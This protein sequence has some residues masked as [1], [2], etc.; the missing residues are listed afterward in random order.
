MIL[1]YAEALDKYGSRHFVRKAL[2]EKQLVRFGQNQYSTDKVYDSMDA[3]IKQYPSAIVTGIT[4]YYIHG[5]TDTVPDTVDLATKRGG[6]K[7]VL[8]YVTQ[9]FIPKEWLDTGSITLFYDGSFIPI[10]DQERMLLELMRNRSKLPFDLYKEIVAAYRAR[11][12]SL[13]IH[14]LQDYAEQMPRGRKHL[15]LILREVF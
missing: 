2:K 10:Y 12:D 14:R 11:Q 6:T 9:H 13:N 3:A 5:L 7:I 8:P 4:A 15:G 1:S